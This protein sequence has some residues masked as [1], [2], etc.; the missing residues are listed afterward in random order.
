MK[1]LLL[2]ILIILMVV[3]ILMLKDMNS[4]LSEVTFPREY[5]THYDISVPE[6]CPITLCDSLYAPP[7]G[8]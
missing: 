5:H 2:L 1:D 4:T 3:A 6:G 8:D 7:K